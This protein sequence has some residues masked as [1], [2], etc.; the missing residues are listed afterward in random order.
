MIYGIWAILFQKL[1]QSYSLKNSS[2]YIFFVMQHVAPQLFSITSTSC[3]I[4]SIMAYAFFLPIFNIHA[5]AGPI[6]SLM[7]S[8]IIQHEN[9]VICKPNLCIQFKNHVGTIDTLREG[10][11]SEVCGVTR[12]LP[13]VEGWLSSTWFQLWC[14]RAGIQ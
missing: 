2:M 12:W 4:Y 6:Y 1:I 5:L 7:P 10:G 14:R 9:F 11:T 8:F 13:W 3:L